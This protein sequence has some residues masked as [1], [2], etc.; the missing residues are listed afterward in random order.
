MSKQAARDFLKQVA[1]DPHLQ[2]KLVAFARQQ[3]YA[4]DVQELTEDELR[5]VAGG[6]MAADS[7]HVDVGRIEFKT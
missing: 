5:G 6:T 7:I 3:G 4:F 2:Q 1:E